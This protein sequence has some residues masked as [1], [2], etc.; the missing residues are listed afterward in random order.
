MAGPA[1]DLRHD[2]YKVDYLP[3]NDRIRYTIHPNAR[4]EILKHLLL[5]NHQI[6]EQEV[7]AGLWSKPTKV[8]QPK[9]QTELDL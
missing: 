4:R 5:L 9:S 2:F 6:H 1:I 8:K 3:E 7:Q